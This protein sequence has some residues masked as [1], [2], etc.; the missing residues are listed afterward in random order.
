MSD[1]LERQLAE[2]HEEIDALV[3]T[4]VGLTE[5]VEEL[6]RQLS[7]TR[8]ELAEARVENA[9]LDATDDALD[10]ENTSLCNE[11]GDLETL[12]DATRAE[13]AEARAILSDF[14]RETDAWN[15]SMEAIIG[16]PPGYCWQTLER[17]RVLAPGTESTSEGGE[18]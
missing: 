10:A 3:R 15:A 12:L 17:A 5:T 2:A 4:K 14:V 8:A 11:V 13:L 1:D 18:K 9:Q 6:D 7:A 16:R